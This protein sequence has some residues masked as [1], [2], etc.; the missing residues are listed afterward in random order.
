[1]FCG[2]LLQC[3]SQ[4]RTSTGKCMDAIRAVIRYT[5]TQTEVAEHPRVSG[6]ITVSLRS[7]REKTALN[8]LP[9]RYPNR[10]NIEVTEVV[11][12]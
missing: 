4:Q 8:Y 10:H 2:V 12:L 9:R 5:F 7:A 3:K 11:Y 1:M 6:L